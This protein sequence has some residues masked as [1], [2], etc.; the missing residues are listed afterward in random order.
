MA[1]FSIQGK[2]IDKHNELA[3]P[4]AKVTAYE[5]DKVTSGFKSDFVAEGLTDLSGGFNITFTW[6]YDL[7]ISGNRPDIIFRVAQKIDGIDKII[8]NENPATETRWNIGD[9]LSVTLESEGGVY[10]N[11]TPTGQPYDELFVFTRVGIIGVNDIDT[12]GSGASGYAYPDIDPSAPNSRAA[13][14]PFGSTLHIAGWFGQF[15]NI[16]RYKL[17]YSPD[18]VNYTDISDPLSNTYY[19][20]APGGGQWITLPM[21]PFSEGGQSNVYKMPYLEKPGQPWI[22]PDLLTKWDTSKVPDGLYSLRIEGFKWSGSALVP[23]NMPSDLLIDPNYGILNLQIDNSPPVSMINEI[24]YN[25]APVNICDIVP[26]STGTLSVKFE[27]SDSNGHLREYVLNAMYGH[28]EIVSPLPADA[29][30]NYS[31]HIDLSRQWQGGDLTADYD[32]SIYTKAKMPSCAYQFRLDV[33][34]RTTNGYGLIYH[35][36]EDTFHITLNRP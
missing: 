4:Y 5:V 15:A 27:A 34:K 10:V 8:Y 24:K 28:N 22:F 3:I 9:Y 29:T 30:D 32:G 20:F 11:P 18:G 35:D 16:A 21:G 6:P 36:V 2:V 33:T 7:S 13:N 25:G 17:Q 1:T 26:F 12:V 31:N 23:V 14:S 19:E